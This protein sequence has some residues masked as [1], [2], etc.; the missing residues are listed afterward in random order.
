MSTIHQT[1]ESTIMRKDPSIS[2]DI[3]NQSLGKQ[4]KKKDA[5]EFVMKMGTIH[6]TYKSTIMKK[7]ASISKE[8]KESRFNEKDPKIIGNSNLKVEEEEWNQIQCDRLNPYVGSHIKA[9]ANFSGSNNIT[10]QKLKVDQYVSI[11]PILNE[12]TEQNNATTNIQNL[13]MEVVKELP[14]EKKVQWTCYTCNIT[15][16]TKTSLKSHL[17]IHVLKG[18]RKRKSFETSSSPISDEKKK[19]WNCSIC[20]S[21]MKHFVPFFK[22]KESLNLHIA[23]AHEAKKI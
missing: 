2:I 13:D 17:N 5:K 12:Q 18:H 14:V 9:K 20:D 15:F 23:T 16:E 22:S 3:Y 8:S 6:Q 7:G 21:E 4:K 11:N 19:R 10:L 1:Y